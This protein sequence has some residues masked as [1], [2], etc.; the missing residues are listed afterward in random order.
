MTDGMTCAEGHTGGYCAHGLDDAA[1]GFEPGVEVLG[2]LVRADQRGYKTQQSLLGLGVALFVGQETSQC[3]DAMVDSPDARA[4][5]NALRRRRGQ[6][7][8]KHDKAGVPL[9][10]GEQ[11]FSVTP[12]VARHTRERLVL[13]AR[14]TRWDRD[15]SYHGVLAVLAV[16]GELLHAFG[17]GHVVGQ[18]PANDLGGVGETAGAQRDDAVGVLGRGVLCDFENLVPVRVWGQA[19]SCADDLVAEGMLEPFEG[20]GVLGERVGRDDV[21]ALK[22]ESVFDVVCGCFVEVEAVCDVWNRAVVEGWLEVV[23]AV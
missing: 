8:I 16:R 18:H 10:Q 3:L 4:Q 7:R 23:D 21:H 6:F 19:G 9:R 11:L 20:V 14:Q 22:T 15:V 13:A 17:S 5:P 2:V 1:H 12:V